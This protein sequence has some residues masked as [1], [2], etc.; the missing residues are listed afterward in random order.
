MNYSIVAV[1]GVIALVTL[2]WVSVGRFRFTGLVRTLEEEKEMQ[3]EIDG[4]LEGTKGVD[5]ED[6]A[7]K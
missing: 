3:R 7:S 6:D 4:T 2:Q 1:G 5:V